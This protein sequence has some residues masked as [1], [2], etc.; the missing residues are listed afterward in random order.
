MSNSPFL[1]D[2]PTR[3]YTYA[4]NRD[5]TG[6]DIMLLTTLVND[7]PK[8][9]ARCDATPKCVGFN[10]DGWLK[11][12]IIPRELWTELATI[13][14][15]TDTSGLYYVGEPVTFDI[16]NFGTTFIDISDK[17]TQILEQPDATVD[18]DKTDN[19]RQKLFNDTI[20]IDWKLIL[21]V[22]FKL[23]II[24][25]FIGFGLWFFVWRKKP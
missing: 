14:K 16:T 9:K 12:K 10:T 22:I 15:A 13:D 8:L 4:Q 11:S 23:T 5:S 25:L 18:A 20:H 2:N 19:I 1:V 24:C 7:V 3:E 6:N 17:R 21:Y